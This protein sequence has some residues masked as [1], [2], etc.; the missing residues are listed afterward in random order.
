MSKFS[1]KVEEFN[2]ANR[3]NGKIEVAIIKEPYG[4]ESNDVISIGIFLD[5]NSSEPDW[6]AHIP[7]DNIEAVIQALKKAKEEL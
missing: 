7:K 2:L 4:K 1:K 3:E 6:K 5:K